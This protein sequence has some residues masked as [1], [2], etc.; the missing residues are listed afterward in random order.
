ML[1]ADEDRGVQF[2]TMEYIKGNDLDRLVRDGGVLPVDLALDCVIQA[3]RGLEAVHAQGIVHRDIKPGNLML[4]ES[5]V[6]RVL[7]L[8]LA[9][10]VEASNPFGE[11]TPGPLTQSG[12]YMGTV[13]FMAP[14]QGIDSSRVDHRADLYSLGCTLCYLLTGRAPFDG[15]ANVLARLMAHQDR[16]PASLRVARPEVPQA[17]DAAYQKMMAK[18][19]DDRPASMGA[20]IAMLEA[21]RSATGKTQEAQSGL[22]SFAATVIMKRAA[23]RG[24]VRDTSVFKR[25]EPGGVQVGP[26]L[27]LEDVLFE[28]QKPN[29]P[30]APTVVETPGAHPRRT[31]PARPRKRARRHSPAFAL[32]AV[33]LLTAV[34]LGYRMIPRQTGQDTIIVNNAS[35]KTYSTSNSNTSG[36]QSTTPRPDPPTGSTLFQVGSV[37]V[38]TEKRWRLE[39]VERDARSF[40]ARV[41][42]RDMLREVRGPI[43]GNQFE[44]RAA[45]VKLIRGSAGN[46]NKGTIQGNSIVMTWN[47]RD[48][49]STTL[50]M[51]RPGAESPGAFASGST[52][53]VATCYMAPVDPQTWTALAVTAD[54]GR[55]FIGG[56]TQVPVLLNVHTGHPINMKSRFDWEGASILD[57]AMT[58]DGRRGVL[59]TWS[60]GKEN[61]SAAKAPFSDRGFLVFYDLTSGAR[62]FPKQQPHPG[63]VSAVAITADGLRALSASSKGELALWDVTTGQVVRPLGPQ[64]GEISSHALSFFPDGRRAASGGRDPRVHVWNLDTGKELAA[65][66]GHEK[67][68]TGLAVSADGRRIVT[69]SFDGTVILRDA[70][71][72]EILHGFTMPEGDTGARVAFDDEGNIVAAGNGQGGTPPKPG[73]LVVWNTQTHDVLR[74]DELPFTRH[75]AVAALPNGRVMTADSHAVRLWK[76]RP[77]NASPPVPRV[78]RDTKPVDLIRQVNDNTFKSGVWHIDNNVLI[79]PPGMGARL[80]FPTVPPLEYRLELEV[81]RVGRDSDYGFALVI[82]VDGRQVE[83]SIDKKDPKGE[84]STGLSGL[85]GLSVFSSLR[86]HRGTLLAPSRPSRFVVTVRRD[87]IDVTCDGTPV[88]DWKGDPKRFIPLVGWRVRDPDKI[89]LATSSAVTFHEITMTPLAAGGR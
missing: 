81:E 26:N 69:G 7:D 58:P 14:E 41:A 27:N 62:L 40:K 25:D 32:G 9:R 77:L 44:W 45:E 19:P 59:G 65:W 20:V 54:G 37:W 72:G 78:S 28:G 5:G 85:D 57:M 38:N 63:N 21:C 15:E 51:E 53:D 43:Q 56:R 71:S 86:V 39:V 73:R 35:V 84:K 50:V 10:L 30:V 11:T 88:M 47:G 24:T 76:P 79:S 64:N 67:M 8:G 18:K 61:Q 42:I 23:P 13:D 33:A 66:P 22:K 55:A 60:V 6:V 46:D 87:A 17:I 75:L 74:L 80:Q 89:F 82:L 48:P 1:D 12:T 2:M 3:A 29:S 83:I 31:A 34:G 4:D 36:S 70:D 68:I 52:F 16:P 49:G